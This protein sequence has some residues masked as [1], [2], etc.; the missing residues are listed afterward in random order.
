MRPVI[1]VKYLK[2]AIELNEVFIEH[3]RDDKGG[4]FYVTPDDGEKLI[5]RQKEIYDGAI[6][7]GNSVTMLNLLRIARITGNTDYERYS[8]EICRTFAREVNHLPIAHTYL[9]MGLN[10]A[11][12]HS[13]EVVIAGDMKSEDTKDILRT[14]RSSFLPD[15]ILLLKSLELSQLAGFTRDLAEIDN[16]PAVY[17]CTNHTCNM[18]VT[19]RNRMMEL[20]ENK[21]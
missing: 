18:P 12:G 16:K 9:M 8:E 17:V 4:A 2:R 13:S 11:T 5:V 15:K 1:D 6:P 19:D 20:L 10:F 3:F 14:L 21:Q 7:S